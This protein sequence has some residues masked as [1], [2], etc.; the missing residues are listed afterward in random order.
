MTIFIIFKNRE[1]IL[2]MSSE[3]TPLQPIL[4]PALTHSSSLCVY[5]RSNSVYFD[6]NFP[7]DTSHHSLRIIKFSHFGLTSVYVVSQPCD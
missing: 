6:L 4:L 5:A 7:F 2:G 1:I 3:I